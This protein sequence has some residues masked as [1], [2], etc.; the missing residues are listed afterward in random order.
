[1]FKLSTNC[2]IQLIHTQTPKRYQVV[3]AKRHQKQ[4]ER[5]SFNSEHDHLK[6]PK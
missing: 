4:I 6:H 2:S 3:S 5:K 1:M